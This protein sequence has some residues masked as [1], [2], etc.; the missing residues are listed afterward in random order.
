MQTEV[1]LGPQHDDRHAPSGAPDVPADGALRVRDPDR[2]VRPVPGDG[3]TS[4]E[5][6]DLQ[7]ARFTI[8]I[9]LSQAS[10]EPERDPVQVLEDVRLLR[11]KFY[12]LITL[13]DRPSKVNFRPHR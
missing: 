12:I 8:E 9:R 4:C 5:R 2:P 13:D 10:A 11:G 1:A 7:V 6:V 3:A